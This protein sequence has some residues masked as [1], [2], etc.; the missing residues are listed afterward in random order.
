M[1]NTPLRIGLVGAGKRGLVHLATIQEMPSL[2]ELAGVCDLPQELAEAAG[3][4]ASTEAYT[5][6]VE[7]LTGANV[8][9]IVV[10]TP[11]ETHHLVAKAAAERGVHML[12]ESPLGTTRAMMDF[13]ADVVAKAGVIVEVGENM[14]RRPTEQ[15]NRS[16]ID[17]GLI[18]N[19]LRVSSYYEDAGHDSVYHTMSRFRY[20]AG[21]DVEEVQAFSRRYELDPSVTTIG[22]GPTPEGPYRSDV[23]D[24]ETWTQAVVFFTNGVVGSCTYVTNWNRPLRWAHPHFVSVEGVAGFIATTPGDMNTLRRVEGGVPFTYERKV[25][26]TGEP[27]SETP[28]RYYYESDP[29]VVYH[30]PFADQGLSYSGRYGPGDSIARAHELRSLHD[31]MTQGN[32]PQYTIAEA[33]R[34]Q[35]LS[36]AITESART[37]RPV[38]ALAVGETTWEYEQ[39]E[40][41]RK[42]TGYDPFKEADALLKNTSRSGAARR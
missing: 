41:F 7:F 19:V 23:L 15:L 35:E 36:I 22:P 1:S 37:G 21:A 31:A 40:A 27:G 14:W 25:D 5:D 3:A 18:G 42:A 33:R 30:N 20:Y 29:E 2:F 13:T 24:A 4:Q 6:V 10:A 38:R 16:A 28:H 32:A 34:D 26:T 11:P 9:A 8:D 12:I 17:A 39:H